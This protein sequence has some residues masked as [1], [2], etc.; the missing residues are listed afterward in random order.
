[1]ATA[2][3]A[4]CKDDDEFSDVLHKLDET[5]LSQLIRDHEAGHLEQICRRRDR[6]R[7]RSGTAGSVAS[8]LIMV[9]SWIQK[10]TDKSDQQTNHRRDNDPINVKNE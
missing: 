10:G 9:A 1:M 4:G 5:S 3:Q 2:L 8:S 7:Q 6:P